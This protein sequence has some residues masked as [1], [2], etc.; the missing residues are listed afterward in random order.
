MSRFLSASR[1][2]EEETSEE[3][4]GGRCTVH[5]IPKGVC[6]FGRGSLSLFARMVLLSPSPSLGWLNQVEETVV[7]DFSVKPAS[8]SLAEYWCIHLLALPHI[9]LSIPPVGFGP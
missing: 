6:Y 8:R 1:S 4:S 7:F 9:S 3:K 5:L 2:L